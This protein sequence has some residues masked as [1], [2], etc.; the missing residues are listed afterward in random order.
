MPVAVKT[1]GSTPG[2]EIPIASMPTST[3]KLVSASV[4]RDPSFESPA[5]LT[6]KTSFCYGSIEVASQ[7]G[8]LKKV[9]SNRP[10]FSVMAYP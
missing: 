7:V 4:L 3:A 1:L 8:S 10:T 6:S 9:I 5:K 2:S